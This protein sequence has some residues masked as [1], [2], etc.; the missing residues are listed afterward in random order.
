MAGTLSLPGALQWLHAEGNGEG[1]HAYTHSMRATHARTPTYVDVSCW[2]A[3]L[4]QPGGT[5]Q[6]AARP[7]VL[8]PKAKEIE[9]KREER[10]GER[11]SAREE[12]ESARAIETNH[13][14]THAHVCTCTRMH[15]W[16]ETEQA[17][18]QG[19]ALALELVTSKKVN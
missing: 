6:C 1:T 17:G 11:E 2:R 15:A 13:T 18:S 14:H 5:S 4:Q 19:V 7:A 16:R 8:I 9:N 3:A 10:E 12:G